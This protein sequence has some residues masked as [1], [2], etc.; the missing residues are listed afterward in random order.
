[1]RG[2][3]H[4]AHFAVPFDMYRGFGFD[5]AEDLGNMFQFKHDFNDYFTGARDLDETRALNP[6]LQTFDAWLAA[7][8][9]QLPRQ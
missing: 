1:M 7:N 3:V 6:S 4:P 8:K 2:A 9:D 5:G